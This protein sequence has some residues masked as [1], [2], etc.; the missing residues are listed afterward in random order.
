MIFKLRIIFP[1]KLSTKDQSKRNTFS[2]HEDSEVFFFSFVH[3]PRKLFENILQKKLEWKRKEKNYEIQ[4]IGIPESGIADGT[5]NTRIGAKSIKE[6][7]LS[8]IFLPYQLPV[9]NLSIL[10]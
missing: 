4:I 10:G 5:G 7:M 2:I 1:A 8:I 6:S 3:I 9:I